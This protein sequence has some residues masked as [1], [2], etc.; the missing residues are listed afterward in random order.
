MFLQNNAKFTNYILWFQINRMA[1]FAIFVQI[2]ALDIADV[3]QDKTQVKA[4]ATKKPMLRRHDCQT[5]QQQF[6]FA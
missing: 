4:Y 1:I 5:R 2:D 6:R 3:K